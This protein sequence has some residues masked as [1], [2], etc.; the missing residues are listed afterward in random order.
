MKSPEL[1]RRS[2]RPVTALRRGLAVLAE[3]G[4]QG[5]EVAT[6]A[7][8][9]GINRTTIYRILA[10]LECEGYVSR[11][12]STHHYR[13]APKVRRLS[14]GFTDALWIT[15]IAAP[16]LMQLLRDTAWPGSLATFDGR[17]MVFRESTHRF[18]SFFVH[19]PMVGRE[20][21][22]STALGQAYLAFSA[23]SVYRPLL[24]AFAS[25]WEA[26]GFG[27]IGIAEAERLLV[28][29]RTRGYA[30]AIGSLEPSVAAVAMPIV[31]GGQVLAC[32][33]V[34]MTP[35]VFHSPRLLRPIREK[36]ARALHAI[37]QKIEMEWPQPRLTRNRST[38]QGPE[39]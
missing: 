31:R 16:A 8:S 9:T 39:R 15:Q 13:L 36:L 32:M 27:P 20:I 34:V 17:H 14:D 38:P 30:T 33:N 11:S 21:P 7:R 5:A 19:K 22:L 29:V 1:K 35:D 18:S 25:D 4:Q 10:T 26:S 12:L 28:K 24:P 37:E 23:K 3:I 6:L 2:Y